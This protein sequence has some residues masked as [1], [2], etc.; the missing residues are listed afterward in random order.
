MFTVLMRVVG[1]GLRMSNAKIA[2]HLL[3]LC[4]CAGSPLAFGSQSEKARS[5]EDN[6]LGRSGWQRRRRSVE[7]SQKGDG[8][9]NEQKLGRGVLFKAEPSLLPDPGWRLPRFIPRHP[10]EQDRFGSIW[11]SSTLLPKTVKCTIC[12]PSCLGDGNG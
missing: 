2:R 5:Q 6:K 10:A 12:S 4:L 11:S 9:R 8:E 1:G 3:Q 7:T